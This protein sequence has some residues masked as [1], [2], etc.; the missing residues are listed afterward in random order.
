MFSVSL[1]YCQE[2]KMALLVWKRL[3]NIFVLHHED[4]RGSGLQVSAYFSHVD[5]L[6]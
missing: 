2:V 6:A 4:V 5:F 3:C 1:V